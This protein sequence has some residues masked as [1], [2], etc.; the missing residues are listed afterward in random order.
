MILK[1]AVIGLGMGFT[2]HVP[3]IEKHPGFRLVAVADPDRTKCKQAVDVYNVHGYSDAFEMMDKEELDLVVVASPHKY[4]GEHAIGAMERGIDVFLEK[5]MASTLEEAQAIYLAYRQ[6]GKKLMVYQP[7]RA[8]AETIAIKR[9]MEK[10]ILGRIYMIKRAASAYFIRTNWKAY[11]NEGGGTLNIHGAHQIDL[12]L[13][14]SGG[15]AQKVNCEMMRVATT[16]DADDCVSI[17]I[18]TDNDVLLDIDMLMAASLSSCPWIIYGVRGTAMYITNDEGIPLLRAR[19][20]D[21]S[22]ELITQTYHCTEDIGDDVKAPWINEDFIIRK[23]DAID[24]YEKCYEYFSLGKEPFVPAEES[25][26]VM[27][28]LKRCQDT[29]GPY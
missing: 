8:F 4:H 7:Q 1:T 9:L 27:E 19:Y 13:H 24:F 6:T 23:E 22:A 11:K 12:L 26:K 3:S 5:P 18:K 10:D 17:L 21:S 15:N 29:A 14:L 2:Y 16:G 20:H 28:A 25:L